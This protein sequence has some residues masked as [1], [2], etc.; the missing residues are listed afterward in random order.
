[1]LPQIPD[2]KAVAERTADTPLDIP[3]GL[4]RYVPKSGQYRFSET[5]IYPLLETNIDVDVMEFSQEPIPKELSD[6]SIQRHGLDTPFRHHKVMNRYIQSL[7]ERKGYEDFVEYNT[8]VE[9]VEKIKEIDKWRLTLRKERPS[10]QKDYWWT[11]DF[12]AVVVASG[13]YIVPYIPE[14]QGLAE[15]AKAYPGSVEHSKG[16]RGPEKYRGKV[17][18]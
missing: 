1:M 9:K 3:D 10:K 12:D 18:W 5:S 11:E 6:L 17:C 13:H 14:I 16:Y 4:P 7:L 8:T 15:F 2:F